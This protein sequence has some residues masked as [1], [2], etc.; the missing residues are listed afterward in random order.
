MNSFITDN[1]VLKNIINNINT[2]RDL[3]LSSLIVGEAHI[4]K[5]RLAKYL[6][7]NATVLDASI[8]DIKIAIKDLDEVIILNFHKVKNID[9][10][11][12]DNKRVIAL[13]NYIGNINII[14]DKFA[15]IYYMPSLKNREED[16]KLLSQ[17]FIKEAK[18][19]LM[20]EDEVDIDY[21][22][23]DISDNIKSLKKYIYQEVLLLSMNE[24]D[25]M[26]SIYNFLYKN[27]KDDDS[28]IYKKFLPLYEKPLIQSGLAKYGSQLQ[29]SQKLGINRNTL[30]KK[31][32]EHKIN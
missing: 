2:T 6:F 29:L 14:N 5:S 19:N 21:K 11:D 12:M 15:F 8:D 20:I 22:E 16:I 18:E 4:G 23:A 10:L 3:Y 28:D 32:N 17:I 31:I 26:S 24:D 25:I 30:R 9:M 13:T 27:Y 7:P 1:K